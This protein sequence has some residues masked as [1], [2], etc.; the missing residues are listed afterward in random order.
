M[1]FKYYKLSPIQMLKKLIV[2]LLTI[3]VNFHFEMKNAFLNKI[4]FHQ[5]LFLLI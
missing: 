5:K 3:F 2:F 1:A 4:Q